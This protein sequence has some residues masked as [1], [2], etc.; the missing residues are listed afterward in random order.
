MKIYFDSNERPE[1]SRI[2]LG[3]P[4]NKILCAL[5][6]VVEDSVSLTYKLNNNYELSFDVDKNIL[7]D[8][9]FI[10]SNGYE[11]LNIKMR[12]Y[13]DNIGW[14]ICD[15]PVTHNDGVREYKTVNAYSCEIEMLQHDIVNLKINCGTTDSYEML[16]EGNV[17]I[18]DDVEFAKEFITFYNREN[19]ELSFLDIVLKASGL[20]GWKIGHV[21][22]IPKEYKYYEDGELKTKYVS[23]SKEKGTF[24]VEAQ[25]LYSFLTQDAAQY[26]SCVFLFDIKH[27][28]I[29]VYRP[30]NLGKNT[31]INIGFR[32]LQ[33]SNEI[34]VN[35]T[36]IFT[37]YTVYGSNELSIEYVN[38]GKRTIENIE[39]FLNEKYLSGKLI[40][41]YK[42]WLEDVEYYRP[43][44]IEYTKMYNEQLDVISELRNR[45]PLDDCSTDWSTF[46][47]EELLEAKANY[48]AQLKGYESFYIDKDG[49]FDVEALNN[50]VDAKDYYQIKDV[51][52]PSIQIEMD[53]RLLDDEDDYAEYIDDYQTDWK[54]Y[55]LDELQV[56]IDT[57]KNTVEVCK[58]K[59]YHI[60][61]DDYESM[62]K[63]DPDN[64]SS[65][66]K[67][68]HTKMYE[69]YLEAAVQLD[70]DNPDSCQYAFNERQKEVDDATDILN[71]YN[72]ERQKI[73]G[74][75]D[76]E[77]WRHNS[78]ASIASV[79]ADGVLSV[80]GQDLKVVDNVLTSNS[81]PHVDSDGVLSFDSDFYFTEQDLSDLSKLYIDGEYVNENM[82]LLSSDTAVS[83]IDEQ[84]KLLDAAKDDLYISSHPQYVYTCD[85]DNFISQYEY[86]NY[87]DNL[88]LGD[89]I[90]LGVRDD[91]VVKLRLISMTYNPMVMNNQLSIEFS[92]MVKSR[93]SRDDFSFLLGS[94]TSRGKSSSSGSGNGYASNEGI[95][96]TPGLIQ[97][98]V[99]NSTFADKL[100]DIVEGVVGD[101]VENEIMNN[102]GIFEYLQAELISADT[103]VANS[104]SFGDLEALVAKIDS[105]LAGNV[106]ADLGHV[107]NLTAKNVNID[108][109]VIR[110]LIAAKISV[111]MLQAGTISTDQFKI[112][113]D[114]GGV[115]IVGNT[116]QFK[117]DNGNI[118][119]QIGRDANNEFTFTLYN[120]D[121][122]GVL[123]DDTGIH[124]S[125]IS[126]GLIVND[127]VS[128]GTLGKEK[129]NFNIV[130][131]DENGNLD[132]G[133]VI[134]NGQG[135]DAEFTSIR[136][137][138]SEVSQAID[139]NSYSIYVI[140]SAGSAFSYG[141]ID[142][143]LSVHVLYKG[144]D[145][146]DKFDD[147]CFVWTRRSADTSG[148]IYWNEQH[149]TGTKQLRITRADVFR[150]ASF[151]CTFSYNGTVLAST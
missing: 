108:E 124:E 54:L 93:A 89:F 32:N 14:F 61:Y 46:T 65:H 81:T 147:S 59:N 129:F 86:K 111:G 2:Y 53:N 79:D 71:S 50:S 97:K 20:R 60:P 96:L 16:V 143:L 87:T 25:D 36:D 82:F 126:D 99:A 91:K 66:T 101:V 114:D 22:D 113:S 100:D 116:M 109:A 29:N 55:G 34:S 68:Y 19:P 134:I 48:E 127:M 30:E 115:E 10:E 144:T 98:L 139:E 18:I 77:T 37:S 90:W 57:Y 13:L 92:N 140:S 67:E 120:A 123:I 75:V 15:S 130:E 150:S 70:A 128:D 3:T 9:E 8:D 94:A 39:H 41:K 80:D 104:G 51:I 107:I 112:M 106:V 125:A 146:T 49:E 142:T 26:F 76:K 145:V 5:N 58:S 43:K 132:A 52:L 131:G 110:E 27:M 62:V 133:K 84:L 148:D 149:S 7:N 38:F 151:G 102:D 122:T 69:K 31:N 118:R 105:L 42:I 21:D 45:L 40:E 73:V 117:D 74:C 33:N 63:D 35:D 95:S 24:T 83:A 56:K 28:I 44:Y 141:N 72:D 103:I 11:W 137:E 138:I 12:V 64:Y 1:P 85:L 121:G 78:Y 136:T 88:E 47:D 6:G 23:L 17:E 4:S 135:I 119:I